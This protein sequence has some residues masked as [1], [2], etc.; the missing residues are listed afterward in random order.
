M[1]EHKFISLFLANKIKLEKCHSMG[2]NPPVAL[3]NIT[4]MTLKGFFVCWF[5]HFFFL[6]NHQIPLTDNCFISDNNFDL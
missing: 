5:F 3:D 4:I 2:K 6:P 1:I